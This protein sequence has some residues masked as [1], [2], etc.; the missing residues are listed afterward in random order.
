MLILMNMTFHEPDQTVEH[1]WYDMAFDLGLTASNNM[2]ISCTPGNRTKIA[3]MKMILTII[4]SQ[5]ELC[6]HIIQCI[7]TKSEP[8][9][10]L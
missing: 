10:I 5:S 3:Y 8:V 2:P 1:R 7:S 9:C 4:E 6:T